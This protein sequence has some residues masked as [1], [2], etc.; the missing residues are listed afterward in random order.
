[1]LFDS[2]PRKIL[3]FYPTPVVELERLSTYLDGPRL[4]MKRDD[5]TGLGMGGNKVRKLEYLIGAAIDQGA[6]CVITGGARQS[7]HCRQTAAAAAVAGL[8]CHLA[9][10]GEEPDELTGNLLLNH[11]FKAHIHWCGEDRKGE[12]IPAICQ[13]LTDQGKRPYVIPY[14]GS[15]IIGAAGFI[16][17]IKELDAQLR[18]SGTTVSHIVF[19][20]SSGGTHAGLQVGSMLFNSRVRMVGI[21]IDKEELEGMVF[22]EFLLKLLNETRTYFEIDGSYTHDDVTLIP[23]YTGEGYGILGKREREAIELTAS[24][25]G[26]LLDPVYTGRAMGGM[27][28][29]VRKGY[30]ASQDTVLFWHTGGTPAIFAYGSELM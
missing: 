2:L 30:F 16:N 18:A 27:I 5:L 8:E 14:G 11:L 29:L 28:D 15:N 3:G 17:G 25:E 21:C 26:I 9:L 24:L 6:D 23:D 20:S 7:N 22:D 19:A 12:R 4:L 10:G 1:M 13:N